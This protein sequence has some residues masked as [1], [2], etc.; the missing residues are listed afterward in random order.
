[1]IRLAPIYRTSSNNFQS[2]YEN[3]TQCKIYGQ[4]D[5]ILLSF[6]IDFQKVFY[7]SLNLVLKSLKHTG[8]RQVVVPM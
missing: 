1:M 5:D 4:L 8:L 7:E 6:N 2:V 3:L